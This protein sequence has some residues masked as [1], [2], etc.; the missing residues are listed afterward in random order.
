[1]TAIS[2]SCSHI[3]LPN[4]K[5][6]NFVNSLP[7]QLRTPFLCVSQILFQ[8]SPV[9]IA[10]SGGV[11]SSTLLAIAALTPGVKY[12]GIIA[13][14]PSLPRANL[15]RALQFAYDIGACVEVILTNEISDPLYAKN[16]PNRCYYC[17][18]ELFK[19]MQEIAQKKNFQTLAYGENADDSPSDR[20]GSKAAVEL[21]VIA[22][23]RQAGL[24]KAQIRLLANFLNLPV[25]SLPAEPCL[26]SR[27]L[28]GTPVTAEALALIEKSELFLRSL[29]FRIVRVRYNYKTN[30]PF[31]LVQVSPQE[32]PKLQEFTRLIE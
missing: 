7:D 20:P 19:K 3:P 5:F 27:I 18:L 6:Q 9:L 10:Y 26:S 8:S 14:S 2:N 15:N 29:G 11:D 22:P 23:L 4:E 16:P 24:H 17:K 31:A 28:H 32:L 12:L 25:A 13:D 21:N 1:M 30:Y